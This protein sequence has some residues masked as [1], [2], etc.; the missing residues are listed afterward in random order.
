MHQSIGS[1]KT[2]RYLRLVSFLCAAIILFSILASIT[3]SDSSRA[4]DL[5]ASP[6]TRHQWGAVTLFHGLPSDHV[7]SI[8]QDS[9]G[10]M[11]FGTDRGLV[12]YDGRRIQRITA[13]GP[14]SARILSIKIDREGVLWLG[15]DQG[16]ARLINGEVKP[17]I[18]THGRTVTAIITPSGNGAMMTTEEGEVIICTNESDGTIAVRRIGPDDHPLLTIESRHMA[19]PLTSL[20]LIDSNLLIGTRGRGLLA[21]DATQI[22][23][24]SRTAGD[25]VKEIVSRPRAFFVRTIDTDSRGRLW[26]GAEASASESG[27]FGG[28]DFL[29]L[30]KMGSALGT[31]SALKTDATGNIWV[32]TEASGVCVF[33]D[34]QRLERF[35]FEN[36]GGGLLSNRIY[37]IFIDREGVAWFGTDRG[38][39]RYDPN[40]VRV[41]TI[42]PNAES[43]FARTLFQASDG[44]L[45]CGT[46]RGLFARDQNGH[47][48]ETEELRGKVIH[49]IASDPQGRLVIGTAAGLYIKTQSTDI[50]K[51]SHVSGAEFTRVANTNGTTDNIRAITTFQSGLY[52]GNFGSGIERLDGNRRTLVW[53][54]VSTGARERQIVSLYAD[55]AR[56][57]IGTADAGVFIFDGKETTTE[58]ALDELIGTAVRSIAGDK[59]RV[60]WLASARG[61]FALK[62]DNLVKIIEGVD[63]RCL[64]VCKSDSQ[65]AIWCASV[66]GGLDKVV[67][68]PNGEHSTSSPEF[69]NSSINSEQGM[70][71]QS[72]FAVIS[73]DDEPGNEALWIGT[74]RGLAHYKP[75]RQAPVLTVTRVMGKRAYAGEELRNG[76]NL[77][78]PQN[79]LAVDVA[80]ISSRTFPEQY[81]YVFT[82]FDDRARV[83]RERRS[84]ESQLLIE[85]LKPGSYS[86][87]VSVFS[88]DLVAS[89]P[90]QFHFTVA[91][92]PFP[93]TSTALSVL[94][95]LAMVAMWWGYRQNLRLRGANRQ[96][97]KTRMQLANETEAERR[98][99]ARDLHDQTLADLRRL[100]MLTD[101]LPVA[102]RKNGHLQ[103]S[104]FR[105]EIEAVST[106]I[107]RI[108]EDLSPSALANVGLVAALEWALADAVAHQPPDKRFEYE[109]SCDQGIEDRLKLD[110]TTQI[111]VFRIFQEALSNICRHSCATKVR[112]S[113]GNDTNGDFLMSLEDD[114]RAFDLDRVRGFETN[115][116]YGFR[117]IKIG[118]GLSNIRSRASLIGADVDWKAGRNGG[119]IFSLRKK[120]AS[121]LKSG[122]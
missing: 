68:E 23:A 112:L 57:W 121:S 75:C 60:L 69:L 87:A 113:L 114:G 5:N 41:E 43:N 10:M 33:R 116:P 17:I 39:C 1:A 48:R 44:T 91:R 45:W 97:A 89:E 40:A 15:T 32:G 90:L 38:V 2:S 80:A 120:L 7:R 86:L 63:A 95:G 19:L 67:L 66:G 29:H 65:D 122:I 72:V 13:E 102:E 54:E 74:T 79:S 73:V 59:K 51:Q 24:G 99:I 8:A 16:A 84:R 92:A 118:R 115:R 83:V 18:E 110:S 53:P 42:S 117:W 52:I 81:Q 56:L 58:R 37:S 71:T 12:K 55:D 50:R 70:P 9:E 111:Q 78:Y 49:S 94:L 108:C 85:G 98:R 35:T 88:N 28:S 100:M 22:K 14:A 109:C 119:M 46:N 82:I 106:E 47:W 30:E 26:F 25:F 21:I 96:L 3:R 6:P 76:I 11:W 103:P 104:Q 64:S 36:T 27:L 101:E 93:W 4:I 61:L 105:S 34:G 20:A 31:V 62:D 77:E 107:R